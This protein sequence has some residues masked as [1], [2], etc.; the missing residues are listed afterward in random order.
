MTLARL[1]A[2]AR[3]PIRRLTRDQRGISAVEFAMLAPL[4][5]VLY[6][7]GV[8]ISQAIAVDRKVT[9]VARTLGD[10]VAQTGSTPLT[11]NDI[12]NIFSASAAVVQ[13][14][15]DSLLQIT[16]SDVKVDAQGN[17]TIFWSDTKNGTARAK[18]ATVTLPTALN[19]PSTHLIWSEVKYSYT[20]PVDI[21]HAGLGHFLV[22]VRPLTDQIYM[23]PRLSDCVLRQGVQTTC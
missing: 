5:V 15:D 1:I 13:P 2:R 22:G 16:V 8:E 20:S 19:V 9:L 7:G 11:T 23:R 14:Y 21:G 6:L 17:A 4:M 10:L 18:G 3:R 12:T